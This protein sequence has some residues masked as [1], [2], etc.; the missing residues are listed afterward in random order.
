[1][2]WFPLTGFGERYS[3]E[4]VDS[5]VDL[6]NARI[7]ACI[8]MTR[9][10]FFGMRHPSGGDASGQADALVA[11]PG[12]RT[13]APWHRSPVSLLAGY[14]HQHAERVLDD[15]MEVGELIRLRLLQR[16][17]LRMGDGLV[18]Y[19]PGLLRIR[20]HDVQRHPAALLHG[21]GVVDGVVRDLQ[22][23]RT[24][25][26]DRVGD[27]LLLPG[28]IARSGLYR[29]LNSRLVMEKRVLAPKTFW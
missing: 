9:D 3:T 27:V 18:V 29:S 12:H 22:L 23:D 11:I 10:R 1:M 19:G 28:A 15:G 24:H 6:I 16:G 17:C 8:A 5:F 14:L 4:E 25:L 13:P 20:H 21:N 2:P 26:V 7:S